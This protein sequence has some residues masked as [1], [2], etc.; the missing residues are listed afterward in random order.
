M[1]YFGLNNASNTQK[2]KYNRSVASLRPTLFGVTFSKSQGVGSPLKTCFRNKQLA[3]ERLAVAGLNVAYWMTE[4]PTKGPF[5]IM[6][7]VVGL[8]CHSHLCTK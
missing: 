1:F 7:I 8:L 5:P 2:N 3:A 6:P 4:F